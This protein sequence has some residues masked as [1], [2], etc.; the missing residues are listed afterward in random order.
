MTKS[1]SEELL[2]QYKQCFQ[3]VGVNRQRVD[4]TNYPLSDILQSYHNLLQW[5]PK[6]PTTQSQQ[7][8]F[9]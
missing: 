5:F 1:K 8:H 2:S 7:V 3:I 4:S 9:N 6:S